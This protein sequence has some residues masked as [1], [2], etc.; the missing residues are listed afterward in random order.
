[1]LQQVQSLLLQKTLQI[2]M[3]DISEHGVMSLNLLLR[4]KK[5]GLVFCSFFLLL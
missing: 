5:G 2:L 3:D 4:T 1:M